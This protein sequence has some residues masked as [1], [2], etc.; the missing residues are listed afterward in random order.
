[1]TGEVVIIGLGN[2]LRK[3]DAVG[4]VAA[5]AL[6]DL[7]LPGVCVVAGV[8][9]PL[10]LLDAWSGARL[11]L[12]ID[13]AVSSPPTPGRVRRCSVGD[14]VDSS[15]ALSSHTVDVGRTYTLGK[16]LGNRVPDV[17]VVFTIDIADTDH[18]VGLTPQVARAIPHV[19]EMA[20]DEINRN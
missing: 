3:D 9:E 16:A 8:A 18:G 17:L 15:G 13:G 11:A 19:V 1:M 6:K 12:V 2:I 14:V 10:S 20:V 7:D 5:V 4:I